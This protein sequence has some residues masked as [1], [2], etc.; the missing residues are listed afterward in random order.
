[1]LSA[2]SL[3]EGWLDKGLS[4]VLLDVR[5]ESQTGQG[6]IPGATNVPERDLDQV[7]VNFPKREFK[8]PVVIYD[9]SGDGAAERVAAKLI[10]AGYPGPRVLTGGYDAWKGAGYQA[11][12]GKPA[13]QVVYVPKLKPGT[14]PVNEFQAFARS[15]PAGVQLLDVRGADEAAKTGMIK[16]A[17]NIPADEIADRLAEISRDKK[18]VLHCNTGTRA[19]MAYTIL[20]EK[21]YQVQYLDATIAPNQDGGF[22]IK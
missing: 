19:E 11:A 8:P 15:I 6:F 9:A 7:L 14:I 12:T 18:V 22:T 2:Q 21:G 13:T 4:L 16:G 1:M 3:K 10:K 17:V 5:P 20:K